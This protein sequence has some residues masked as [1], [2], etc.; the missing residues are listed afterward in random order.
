[1][2]S[3][4]RLSLRADTS[5]VDAT[6]A[7]TKWI[8]MKCCLNLPGLQRMNPLLSHQ[9]PAKVVKVYFNKSRKWQIVD[10]GLHMTCL[11]S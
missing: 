10:T 2:P 11:L 5:L 4:D 1:M 6:T 7:F 3:Y 9:I 8:A